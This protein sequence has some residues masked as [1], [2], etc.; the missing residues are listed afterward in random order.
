MKNFFKQH[1]LLIFLLGLFGFLFYFLL[2]SH[3]LLPRNDGW[4]SGGSTWGD[5]AFHLSLI[6]AIKERGFSA[7]KEHPVFPGEK[8]RYP[9]LFDLISASLLKIGL[10][11]RLSLILPTFICLI[12]SLVLFYFLTFQ[13]T[14]S[15]LVSFFVPFLFF[16][17]GSIFGLYYFLKDFSQSNLN[18]WD[19]LL[20]QPY[21][22]AHLADYKIHF[23]NL[24][25]DYFL[26]QRAFVLGLLLGI[27]AIFF[28]WNYW[29][30]REKKYLFFLGLIM[31][32]LPISHTHTFLSLGLVI[33]FV[34]FFD[35]AKNFREFKKF[36]LNW[37]YFALPFLIL[38]PW[39]IFWLWP[40][41]SKTSGFFRFGFGWLKKEENFF[42]FWIKNLGLYLLVF[43]LAF[44]SIRKK[45]KIFYL[46]FLFLFLISNLV[47]FQPHIYDNMKVMIWWFFMSLIL[48][49]EWWKIL[50]KEKLKIKSL[51]LIIPL[52]LALTIVG[53]LSTI[54]EVNLRYLMFSQEDLALAE[55]IKA[56]TPLEAI[57]LTSDKHNHPIPCL[58]GRK[59]LMGYRGWLWT[60]GIDFRKREKE[61]KTIFQ[62][63]DE[64]WKLIKQYQISYAVFDNRALE[65]YQ[66]NLQ[67]FLDNF[68]IIYQS[69]NYLVFSFEKIYNN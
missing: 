66:A 67:F 57:F 17:N 46:P 34:F 42:W 31:G 32:I 69:E 51:W 44:L 15:S 33:A 25:A 49:G 5:L 28:L 7:L 27:L 14:R 30:K 20:N 40:E 52:F 38:S 29:E 58:T 3:F 53:I 18:L 11:L 60:H 1:W 36:F 8:L 35:L 10:S 65:Q 22:Y 45:L 43:F 68:P 12:A 4:Y 21:Q 63:K 55:F 56:N 54:R 62:G 23:S 13:I 2:S 39:Q 37:F 47:I 9:F 59:I 41:N 50:L 26:P 64:E 16:F 61:I 24:I 6:T 48:V 19:F